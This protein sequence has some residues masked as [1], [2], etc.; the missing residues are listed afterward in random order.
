[1]SSFLNYKGYKLLSNILKEISGI[2]IYVTTGII[3]FV[4]FNF[5]MIFIKDIKRK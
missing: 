2:Q 3:V 4:L 1:M 5:F